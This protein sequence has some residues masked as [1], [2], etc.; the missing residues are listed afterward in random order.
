MSMEIKSW[1]AHRQAKNDSSHGR[2]YWVTD[3]TSVEEGEALL[4][5]IEVHV[6]CPRLLWLHVCV[7]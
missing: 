5:L 2:A 4:M 6:S 7:S 1:L 3:D